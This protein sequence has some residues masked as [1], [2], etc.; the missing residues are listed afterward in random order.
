MIEN[1]KPLGYTE[2]INRYK[3]DVFPPWKQSFLSLRG[4][5]KSFI[6][7]GKTTD[8]YPP[9]YDPGNDLGAHLTFALKYEGVNLDVLAALFELSP[10]QELTEF[11]KSQP[12]GKY[13][14]RIWFLYEWLTG[15]KI[16]VDDLRQGNYI[17]V[18]NPDTYYSLPDN[19]SKRSQRHRIKIN[20]PGT[21]AY[22]PLVRRTQKLKDYEKMRLS[23]KAREL[24]KQYPE[25]LLY[26]ATQY[27]YA[28]E[29]KSS[30]EI[31]REQ[32]EKR[33]IARF[34]E[35][36]RSAPG[37]DSISRE[38]LVRLQK[39]IVDERF[40]AD[41]FRDFQNYVGQSISPARELIHFVAPK[42]DDLPAMMQGWIECSKQMLQSDI[43]PVI[44]A[45]VAGFGFVFLHPF[46]D[47]NGRLHRYLIHHVLS[48]KKFTP[49]DLI[50]PVSAT[51]LKQIAKYNET[52]EQFSREIMK[53][54]EYQIDDEGR[55]TV[56]NDTA[57]YYRYPDMTYQAERLYEFV[58]N[59]I[60]HEL[61]PELEY[62][63]IFE[64]SRRKIRDIIDMPD[65]RL[66]LF[67]RLCLDGKG[68]ISKAKRNM[69]SYLNDSEIEQM[70][71]IV[72]SEIGRF[73]GGSE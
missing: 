60:E 25:E 66:D 10:E 44:T 12:V 50:F 11:I 13:S 52:L 39:E 42:P 68:R 64:Q 16:P 46:E 20:L 21:A 57:R 22:C 61:A 34:I 72:S 4:E 47:G 27:L 62:L 32:P 7:E 26:R 14:R 48:T 55:M 15:E 73:K 71:Q 2:I 3:L 30:F 35:L 63:Y 69:F 23:E 40:A 5:R 33:R 31:E 24:L 53:R 65:R 49:Q 6:D 54:T 45:A 19:L 1:L 28:K 51:M 43:D 59:T 38:G 56:L 29:T 18:L 41:D 58:D 67:I 9:R 17:P 8:I 37:S 70:E 36:L